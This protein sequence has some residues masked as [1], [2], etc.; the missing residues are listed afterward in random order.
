MYPKIAHPP[1]DEVAP[2]VSPVDVVEG[3]ELSVDDA[4]EK[5][6]LWQVDLAHVFLGDL[7]RGRDPCTCR[8]RSRRR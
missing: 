3:G 5:G 4:G 8:G 2:A 1:E 6:G 7:R